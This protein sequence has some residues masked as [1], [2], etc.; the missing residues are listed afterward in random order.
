MG[1]VDIIGIAFGLAMDAFAVA[2]AAS[3]ALKE[4]TGRQT[5]RLAFHFGLFQALMPVVGW[6]AGSTLTRWVEAWSH[7]IAFGLLLFVGGKMIWEAVRG[8]ERKGDP[9]K[10]LT[11]VS[12]SVATS[13]DALVVGVSFAMLDVTIWWPCLIIGVVAAGMTVVGLKIGSKLGQRFGSRMEV[14]GGLV[15]VAIGVRVLVMNL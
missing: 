1:L 3:V 12:L 2:I 11:M 13:I 14:L 10:G 7:W 9:T 8:G 6:L 4:V 5:F 15:L